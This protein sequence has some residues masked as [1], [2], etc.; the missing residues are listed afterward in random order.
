MTT[1]LCY[2]NYYLCVS[3]PHLCQTFVAVFCKT[4]VSGKTKM[5]ISCFTESSA[6]P[7]IIIFMY[8]IIWNIQQAVGPHFVL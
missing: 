7:A 2:T 1:I 8:K 5:I 4:P 6:M 3:R